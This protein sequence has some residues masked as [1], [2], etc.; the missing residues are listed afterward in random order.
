MW[1]EAHPGEKHR[2][3]EYKPGEMWP[4]TEEIERTAH[5]Y[6]AWPQVLVTQFTPGVRARELWFAVEDYNR[7]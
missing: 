5:E 7:P 2:Y 3:R 6:H 4:Y 1:F